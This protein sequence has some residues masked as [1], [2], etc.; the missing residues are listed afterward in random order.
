MNGFVIKAQLPSLNEY[1]NACRSHWSKGAEFKSS[2]ESLIGWS[3][4][5]SINT[6][7]LRPIE[8]PCEI[9]I[10]WHESTKRRDVDN[11]QSAQKFILDA[12]QHFKIIKND[13]RRYVRQIRH[14]VVDDK[15]DYVTVI[16]CESEENKK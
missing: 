15:E 16:L 7:Q 14:E 8:K 2:V 13:S 3:S 1:T 12:L 5:R 6:G 11:I 9:H 10:Y 4:R